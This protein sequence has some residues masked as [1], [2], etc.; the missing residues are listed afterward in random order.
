MYNVR[1]C[2]KCLQYDGFVN[3]PSRCHEPRSSL[4]LISNLN[5]DNLMKNLQP[6]TTTSKGPISGVHFNY[7]Y[8]SCISIGRHTQTKVNF[9]TV[10]GY[11][12]RGLTFWMYQHPTRRRDDRTL[13]AVQ[14]QSEQ[15]LLFVSTIRKSIL[16]KSQYLYTIGTITSPSR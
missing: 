3:N 4:L 5:R 16:C 12:T 1:H 6:A 11:C 10:D 13:I 8:N 9:S 7:Y 2:S 15:N 14:L